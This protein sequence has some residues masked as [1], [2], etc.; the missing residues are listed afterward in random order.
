VVSF[1]LVTSLAI[2]RGASAAEFDYRLDPV[3][4]A[5]DTW[6]FVGRNEDITA[7]NGGNVANTAFVVTSEGVVIIDSGPSRRYAWQ[8]RAAIRRVSARPVV[9]VFN[10]HQHGD[11]V[12]GNQAYPNLVEAMP[13][14]IDSIRS[15]GIADA[16]E[17]LRSSPDAAAGTE[18]S[19]PTTAVKPGRFKMGSHEFELIMA[20]GHTGADLAIFDHTTG[21]L[22]AGDL[23]FNGRAPSFANADLDEWIDALTRLETFRLRMLVPGHGAPSR[24]AQ[25]IRETRDY[26]LW[27]SGRLE[28][29][30]ADGM[31]MDDLIALPPPER[32]RKLARIEAEYARSVRQLYPQLE[33]LQRGAAGSAR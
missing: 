25:P 2:A 31:P 1:A 28:Q 10:T 17:M 18:S 32:F 5:T 27:L 20:K 15:D 14:T 8:A 24:N 3:E 26:L 12:L 11:H 4:V 23:V 33:Q 16:G 9:R 30:A 29:A 6:V 19:V 13:A 22:F 7:T 21:V